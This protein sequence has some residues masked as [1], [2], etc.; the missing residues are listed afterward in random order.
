MSDQISR[1]CWSG[2]AP[3]GNGCLLLPTYRCSD[4]PMDRMC[5]LC[6]LWPEHGQKNRE[7]IDPNHFEVRVNMHTLDAARV[8]DCPESLREIIGISLDARGLQEE[9]DYTLAIKRD[10]EMKGI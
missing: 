10:Y 4:A 9:I 1:Q 7:Q 2:E 8:L 6:G 5:K 3:D